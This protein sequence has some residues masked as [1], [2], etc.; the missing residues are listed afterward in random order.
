[1]K[2]LLARIGYALGHAN[3]SPELK[4][5]KVRGDRWRPSVVWVP[6]ETKVDENFSS[7]RTLDHRLYL[8]STLTGEIRRFPHKV[9]GKSVRRADKRARHL[10]RARALHA[11]ASAAPDARPAAA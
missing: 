9:R 6:K 8:R 4:L 2:S 10:L 5:R 11:A 1:M 3:K 7:F